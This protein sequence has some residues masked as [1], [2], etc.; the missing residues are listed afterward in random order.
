MDR[1]S[2][3][4]GEVV[5]AVRQ[6][7]GSVGGEVAVVRS[8]LR[9]CPLGAHVDHQ[10]GHVTGCTLDEAVLLA[11]IPRDDGLVRLWSVDFEGAVEFSLDSIPPAEEGDWG[12]YPRGCAWALLRAHG[13]RHGL[14]GVIAGPLPV[15]GLSSSAAVDVAYLLA[16]EHA[17]GLS[18]AV[19]ENVVLAQQVENG[20]IGLNN[21]IL[22]QSIIL[23]SRSGHLTWLDCLDRKFDHVPT[24][25]G[26]QFD[27]VVAYSGL[28]QGL[29]GTGYNQ[30][31]SECLAAAR[32]LFELAGRP[33]HHQ[34]T[35][36]NVPPEVFAEHRELLPE[37]LR[38][39]AAHFFGEQDRVAQG[40]AAWQAGDLATV[41]ALMTE[42]GRSSIEN[43]ECGSPHL[44][45]LY[46]ILRD[47]PGVYGTRFSGAGFRG[48]CLALAEPGARESLCALIADQYPKRHP[49][50]AACY[51]VHFCSPSGPARM[52]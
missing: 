1:E 13:I 17:N 33:A 26:V 30:R 43:Y 50:V 36:R 34:P 31:V 2:R 15:G 8:P 44:I 9:I 49:D 27:I 37:L 38:K 41:G 4:I 45:S 40:I 25:A 28:S 20:F 22:D 7:T 3:R 32:E 46:E 52:L 23:G 47:A 10:H 6:R 5:E 35:L 51:S 48:S 12:S 24:P 11:F 39:R 21:G 29:V 42:S 14:D 18:L 16:L 19:D